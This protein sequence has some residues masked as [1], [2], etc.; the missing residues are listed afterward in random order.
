M[1]INEDAQ[2]LSQ[3]VRDRGLQLLSL[4]NAD[5]LAHRLPFKRVGRIVAG[6]YDPVRVLPGEAKDVLQVDTLIVGNR[7]ALRSATQGFITVVVTSLSG[8]YAL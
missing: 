2:L 7:C 6:R 5:A 1:V 8:F 4:P 3:A